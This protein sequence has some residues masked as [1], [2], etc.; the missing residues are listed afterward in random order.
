MGLNVLAVDNPGDGRDVKAGLR[1]YVFEYHRLQMRLIT[2]DEIVV[3]VVHYSLHRAF[4][5][6][7]ALLQRLH[8]PFCGIQLLLDKGGCLFFLPVGRALRV[9]QQ[10]GVLGIQRLDGGQLVVLLQHD[11]D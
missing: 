2:I 5:S 8:K 1:R 3:L 4:Q 7:V 10:L 6:V 9:G 11:G